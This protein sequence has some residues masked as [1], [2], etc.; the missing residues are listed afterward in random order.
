MFNIR[1]IN[2]IYELGSFNTIILKDFL[3]SKHKQFPIEKIVEYTMIFFDFLKNLYNKFDLIGEINLVR[4]DI[5]KPTRTK[6]YWL[7]NKQK[8]QE[9]PINSLEIDFNLDEL[10]NTSKIKSILN[11]IYGPL[12][13]G[14]GSKELSINGILEVL[15]FKAR[16][17]IK[18]LKTA[19]KK[20]KELMRKAKIE[21][22]NNNK[23]NAIKLYNNAKNFAKY[24][25]L[26]SEFKKIEKFLQK[27]II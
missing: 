13:L 24:W 14:F 5:T 10:N 8:F 25:N 27:I 6:N 1:V 15:L 22:K 17:N 11:S 12:L 2:E 7:Y 3:G 26:K 9:Y 18:D 23:E 20:V 16:T 21:C 19:K 4:H